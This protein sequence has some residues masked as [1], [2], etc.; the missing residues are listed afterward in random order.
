MPWYWRSAQS[1]SRS[2][3]CPS[4]PRRIRA[5][6]GSVRAAEGY[7]RTSVSRGTASNEA[8]SISNPYSGEAGTRQY[9]GLSEAPEHPDADAANTG[10]VRGCDILAQCDV[11]PCP[12]LRTRQELDSFVTTLHPE[13]ARRYHPKAPLLTAVIM[14]S[15]SRSCAGGPLHRPR[16]VMALITIAGLNPRCDRPS[17]FDP[18]A[19]AS[20]PPS[21]AETASAGKRVAGPI[22]MEALDDRVPEVFVMRGEPRGSEKLVFLHGMC[23]H[24]LGYAQAF[25]WSASKYG[26]L[27]APQGDIACGKGPWASWSAD[28]QALDARI[29]QAFH[30]LGHPDPIEDVVAMGYSQGATR[31]EALARRWPRRYTHLVLMGAPQAPSPHGLSV[32]ALVSMAGE[33]DRQDLMKAGDRAFRAAGIPSTYIT[34]PEATHGAMGPTP[35]RT[36]SQAL[37]W[38]FTR[39]QP[40]QAH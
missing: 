37:D 36:M 7:G 38:L 9:T 33:R 21:T 10:E 28:L 22:R 6:A 30:A 18:R 4:A 25:Q 14:T 24:G 32:R 3:C 39:S 40:K 5:A 27:I 26:T 20:P 35:E 23:G 31:A 12:K 8:S 11:G 13:S 19:A 16:R 15:K 2:T 17:T 29:V 34:I 1:R